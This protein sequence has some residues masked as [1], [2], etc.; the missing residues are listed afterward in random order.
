MNLVVFGDSWPN[1]A[2]LKQGEKTFGKILFELLNAKQYIHCAIGGSSNDRTVLQLHNFVK[3]M[4]TSKEHLAV[5]FLTDVSRRSFI[6]EEDE[7]IDIKIPANVEEEQDILRKNWYKYFYSKT[8][9]NFDHCRNI[10]SLQKI[11]RD[12]NI[13][14][15]YIQGWGSAPID[16]SGVDQSKIYPKTCAELFGCLEVGDEFHIDRGNQYITP[17]KSH[18]NQQGHVLIAQTLYK[19]ILTT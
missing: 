12:H 10:L 6:N 8:Q 4:D 9:S 3:T 19:W 15:Y 2:E 14:D 11:C 17:N 5:F 7:I 1:G 16:F 13:K 18:P